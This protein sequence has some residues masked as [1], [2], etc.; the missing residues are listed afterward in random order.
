MRHALLVVAVVLFGM[1][2]ASAAEAQDA[3]AASDTAG[4]SDDEARALF[5]AAEIAYSDGRFESALESFQR[6]YDLSGR[7]ELL[8]NIGLSAE[9]LRQDERALAAYQGYLRERP[10]TPN[11]ASVEARIRILEQAIAAHTP[12]PPPEVE[13]TPPPTDAAPPPP[14]ATPAAS[15]GPDAGALVL[16]VVGGV[17]AIAG[18]VL[19]GVGMMDTASVEHASYPAHWSD[20]QGA[21]DRAFPLTLTGGIALGVGAAAAIGGVLWIALGTSPT[22]S[23][24]SVSASLGLDGL[25]L[26]GTF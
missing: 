11:R 9:R 6:A 8:Y 2:R 26:R 13:S 23:G 19:L 22:G 21:Y 12:A 15:S 1:A 7:P 10:D 17:I 18:A 16:T 20:V 24:G 3:A 25:T 14:S 5:A 4:R